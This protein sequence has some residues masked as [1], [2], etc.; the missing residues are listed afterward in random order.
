MRVGIVD[1]HLRSGESA[2]FYLAAE[3][4]LA[5]LDLSVP[6][7]PDPTRIL[8]QSD[9]VDQFGRLATATGVT[10][11]ALFATHFLEDNLLEPEDGRRQPALLA[12]RDLGLRAARMGVPT[13]V[14]PLLGASSLGPDGD[15][16]PA[17]Q[18]IALVHLLAQI[19]SWRDLGS[20]RYALKTTL[21]ADELCPLLDRGAPRSVGVCFDPS[22]SLALAVDPALELRR[23]GPRV[24]HVHLK[25]RR[26]RG[27][28]P[29][30]P[31]GTGALD[32]PQ[33]LAT[34]RETDYAGPIILDT[35]GGTSPVDSARA[36]LAYCRNLAA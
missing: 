30:A 6:R 26:G 10:V 11:S 25:D 15:T 2:A 14:I 23:L 33:I 36:N 17:S 21:P 19:D 12:L 22:L 27:M 31:L 3:L 18:R 1:H 29:A 24:L 16:A 35:P 9:F 5:S 4:G 8:F 28:G 20:T 7:A 34:L 32:C 13:V